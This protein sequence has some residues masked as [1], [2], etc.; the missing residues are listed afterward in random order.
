MRLLLGVLLVAAT[1]GSVA[2]GSDDSSKSAGGDDRFAPTVTGPT[3]ATAGA[4]TGEGA[5]GGAGATAGEN[6]GG[7][8]GST[9][10][11]SRSR[12]RR[13][14]SQS[15]RKRLRSRRPTRRGDF[16]GSAATTYFEGRS[17]CLSI[18]L[19]S[20]ARGYGAASEQPEDV[21]QAYAAREAPNTGFREAAAQGCLDGINSRIRRGQ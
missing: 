14:Q 11:R 5:T 3:G 17:R 1:L 4:A 16:T 21:A 9:S 18:P 8:T 13:S 12:T 19:R 2:C 6:A 15:E 7:A 10:S 20:L